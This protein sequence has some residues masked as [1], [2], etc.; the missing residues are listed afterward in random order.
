M[1]DLSALIETLEHRWM[2]AWIN[3]DSRALK[4]LTSRK[5]RLVIGT[6]PSVILDSSSWLAAAHSRFTCSSYRFGDVYARSLGPIAVFAT[7]LTM[8]AT[9]D[10]HDWTGQFWVTDI[11]RKGSIR[12]QWRMIERVIS[13]PDEDSQVPGAVR[14]LQLWR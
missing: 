8:E 14:A 5:F 10:G 4:A 13:R 11:W 7:Q 9:I 12:R 1:A 6:K 3:R 2:R